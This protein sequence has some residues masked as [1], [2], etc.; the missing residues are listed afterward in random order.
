MVDYVGAHVKVHDTMT[1]NFEREDQV[2]I[3]DSNGGYHNQL[4][5][6]NSLLDVMICAFA[7]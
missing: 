4:P 3:F 5:T 2:H 7:L 6:T 1:L